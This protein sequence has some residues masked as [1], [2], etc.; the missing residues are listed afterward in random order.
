LMCSCRGSY[1]VALIAVDAALWQ[2]ADNE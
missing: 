2:K 1:N